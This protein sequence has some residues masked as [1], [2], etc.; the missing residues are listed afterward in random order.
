MNSDPPSK[1]EKP[2]FW[3]T[4]P[5]V[6]AQLA[7]LIVA[8]SGLLA[9]LLHPKHESSTASTAAARDPATP[10]VNAHFVS[11]QVTFDTINGGLQHD[12]PLE[13]WINMSGER[14]AAYAAIGHRDITNASTLSFDVPLKTHPMTRGELPGSW[15]QIRIAPNHN[16]LWTFRCRVLLRFDDATFYEKSFNVSTLDQ[17]A[18]QANL[19]L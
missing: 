3:L 13:V 11:M 10:N 7:A 18:T 1:P 19:P 5:G 8:V 2:S 17:Y 16:E 15:V 14:E 12:T 9:L 6:L 4:L